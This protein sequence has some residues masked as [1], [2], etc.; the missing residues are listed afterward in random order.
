MKPARCSPS[1]RSRTRR[2]GRACR[3]TRTRRNRQARSR[4]MLVDVEELGVDLLS[5]AAFCGGDVSLHTPI[6]QLAVLAL[7]GWRIGEW[8]AAGVVAHLI[9]SDV[10]VDRQQGMGAERVLVP[11][12]DVPCQHS[13]MLVLSQLIVVI[14]YLTP[15]PRGEQVE[16]E[17]ILAAGRI[18]EPIEDGLIVA[19]VVEGS[20]LR[21]VQKT[22]GSETVDRHEVSKLRGA[23]PKS[24]TSTG[25]AKRA[26]GSIDVAKSFPGAEP[27]TS[28]DLRDQAAFVAEFGVRRTRGRL[29]ALDGA[30]GQLRGE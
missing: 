25:R 5:L 2:G 19:L 21:G 26:V 11:G 12:S 6:Q 23:I 13:L 3:C 8:I 4:W 7:S 16:V 22:P 18:V 1:P 29:H 24:D 28:R 20:E 15:T 30:S 27:R 10:W 14:G 17:D 9:F